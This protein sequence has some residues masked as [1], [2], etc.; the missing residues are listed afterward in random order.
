MSEKE[1]NE[2]IATNDEEKRLKQVVRPYDLEKYV[3]ETVKKEPNKNVKK[4]KVAIIGFAPSTLYMANDL[5]ESW[6]V[7]GM[8]ELYQLGIPDVAKQAGKMLD[9]TKFTRWFELHSRAKDKNGV[10]YCDDVNIETP[11]G[12]NH[13]ANMNTMP[14]PVYMRE[15][16]IKKFN[17]VKN[18]VAFPYQEIV[19]F[20][21]R[22]YFT[23][24][25]SWMLGYALYEGF[26]KCGIDVTKPCSEAIKGNQD[27]LKNY[28]IKEILVAGVDMAVGWAKR[29]NGQDALQNEY[30]S[31]RPS[32]EWVIGIVDGLQMAGVDIKITIPKKS[33]LLKKFSLYGFEDL[34]EETNQIRL[35]LM[36]RLE[37]INSRIELVKKQA[38]TIQTNANQQISN[39]N[40]QLLVMQGTKQEIEL[41]FS[42]WD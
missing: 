8:N 3:K 37:F 9:N 20:F 5:D 15:V 16:D 23:N 26:Q 36:E 30:A 33:S 10:A 42:A 13:I 17:D 39:L 35:D 28:P 32:C 2:K 31:Q 11:Q 27:K 14:F 7:W 18:A 19:K 12:K 34:E 22:K 1:A 25:V 38:E 24:T 21:G 40:S 4:D 29:S 6:E 41:N